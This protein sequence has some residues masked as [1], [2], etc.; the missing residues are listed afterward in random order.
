MITLIDPGE[1]QPLH[2]VVKV[3][4]GGLKG[5]VDDMK[6]N[7]W[8]GRPLLVIESESGYLAWT[9]V[10]TELPLPEKLAWLLFLATSFMSAN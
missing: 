1:I 2:D 5:L 10:V 7:G 3:R 8:Q 4:Q 6:E 9:G